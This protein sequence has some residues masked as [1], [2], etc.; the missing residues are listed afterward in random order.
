MKG[1]Y[2][3]TIRNIV[4]NPEKIKISIKDAGKTSISNNINILTLKIYKKI[5]EKSKT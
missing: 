4:L 2:L 1:L 3:T 5:S